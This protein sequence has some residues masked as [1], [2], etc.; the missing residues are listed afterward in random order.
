M[1]NI[2]G[3]RYFTY[4]LV[5]YLRVYQNKIQS[6]CNL[7]FPFTYIDFS[8]LFSLTLENVGMVECVFES[9][10]IYIFVLNKF[11]I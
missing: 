2:Y 6:I 3:R 1:Y 8:L 10:Q 7:D 9:I 4:I 11:A 5:M